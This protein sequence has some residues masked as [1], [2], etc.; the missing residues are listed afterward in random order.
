MNKIPFFKSKRIIFFATFISVLFLVFTTITVLNF[1]DRQSSSVYAR[2]EKKA[3]QVL[4]EKPQETL[5]LFPI[6]VS[7]AKKH[8]LSAIRSYVGRLQELKNVTLSPEVGGILISLPVEEGDKVTGGETV[9]AKIDTYWNELELE[10]AVNQISLLGVQLT[11]QE[12][13]LDRMERL[14]V[15]NAATE[16]ELD[17]LRTTVD[18]LKLQ[19]EAAH[20][21]KE[22]IEEKI[23]RSKIIAPFDGYVVTKHA[24]IGQLLSPG[25]NIVDIISRGEFDA[26]IMVG[27]AF[28]NRIKVGDQIPLI[29][30]T[31]REEIF[32]EVINIVPY[33]LV[34]SRTF[35]VKL[36]IKDPEEKLKVN[37]SLE[38]FVTTTDPHEGIVVSN[39]AVLERP[40]G[41]TVWV[42]TPQEGNTARVLPV[43]VKI[44][45]R[46]PDQY[47]VSA[48]SDA[49]KEL[50]VDGANVVIEGAERLSD[51]QMVRII[52]ID[53]L[54]LENLPQ[55]SGHQTFDP[56]PRRTP[57]VL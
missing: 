15:K 8:S 7:E 45:I 39:D 6:R 19:L 24:E 3:T 35:P 22:E 28:I 40:E 14:L 10:K 17:S 27:E 43:S 53:P 48:D 30:E 31:T 4:E 38:A 26:V 50:L 36:R 54:I 57:Q 55:A 32:G 20:L 44:N 1:S 23:K 41:Y 5:K 47:L 13:E 33:G 12:K 37:M 52:G 18:E 46:T 21:N 51:N 56:Q 42:A 9:I 25:T 29:V 49:G 11:F 2:D 16:S 34:K